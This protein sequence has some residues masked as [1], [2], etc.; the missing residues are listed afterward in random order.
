[1]AASTAME[2]VIAE[3]LGDVGKLHDEV[4]A[5]AAALPGAADTIHKAGQDAA[6]LVVAA[7]KQVQLD[8]ENAVKNERQAAA[9]ISRSTAQ[10]YQD[11]VAAAR[12]ATEAEVPKLQV[13]FVAL[14]QDVL[15]QVRKEAGA[16]A[17]AGW[18]FKIGLG[19]AGLV[20][21]GAIAGGVIGSAWPGK[22]ASVP[23]AGSPD[24]AKQIEAGRDFL[25]V[26]PQLDDTTRNKVIRM[27]EKNRQ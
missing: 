11:I 14:A 1:M 5:V 23:G 8:L 19:A 13:R 18:K 22:N 6:A 7:G 10:A 24:Q 21:L 16:S 12:A 4:K 17:P 9:D 15:E 20:I 25:Q 26:L 3:L 2:A 27:I